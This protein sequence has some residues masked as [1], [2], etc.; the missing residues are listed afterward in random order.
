MNIIIPIFYYLIMIARKINWLIYRNQV[1]LKGKAYLNFGA[2]IIGMHKKDQ[3]VLGKNIDLYGC[4]SV[5]KKGKI[6]IG[7]YTGMGRRAVI[8]ALDKVE[9]GRFGYIAPDVLIFD[10]NHH[11]IYARDRMIDALGAE[12]GIYARNV[13]TK[14]IKIGNHVWIG[15][16]AM[17]LKGVTIGDRSIVG[18]NAVVTHDVPS[19]VVVAGNPAKIV[20]HIDQEP[21]NPDEIV[22]P[23]EITRMFENDKIVRL[24]DIMKKFIKK[25]NVNK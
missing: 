12:K 24:D 22:S 5:G 16:R 17:I 11:S 20:K 7:D 1:T 19:D 14:P 23:D 3:I 13:A 21:I 25:R 18:A 15:R 10:S 6:I 4:L 8:Q 9:I 2:L